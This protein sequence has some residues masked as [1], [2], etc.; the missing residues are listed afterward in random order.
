MR[1]TARKKFVLARDVIRTLAGHELAGIAGGLK[2]TAKS[3]N[4]E[5]DSIEVCP[6]TTC[7]Q[8]GVF[9]SNTFE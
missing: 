1:K 9:C 6:S 4:P 5:C 3:G 7:P 8:S 2:I